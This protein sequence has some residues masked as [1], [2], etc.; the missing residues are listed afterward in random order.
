[1]QTR[2]IPLANTELS[3]VGIGAM[4]FADF[5]G[6]VTEEQA[7]SILDKARASGINPVVRLRSLTVVSLVHCCRHQF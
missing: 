4:S 2:H 5:Y 3:A 7:H 6:P 1:M